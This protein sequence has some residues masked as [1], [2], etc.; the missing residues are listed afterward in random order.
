M[1]KPLPC[2]PEL[3]REIRYSITQEVVL[4]QSDFDHTEQLKTLVSE[5]WKAAVLD[6]GNTNSLNQNEKQKIKH[7]TPG[8]TYRFGDRNY[9]HHFKLLIYQSHW[10]AKMWLNTDIIVSDILC[11]YQENQ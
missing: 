2:D 8:N 7:H 10:E 6:S 1:R 3:P 5:S 4:Y 11:F 9:F